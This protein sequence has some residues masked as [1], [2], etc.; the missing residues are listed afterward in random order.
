MKY[1]VAV[2]VKTVETWEIVADD[3]AGARELWEEGSLLST[4]GY[5]MEKILSVKEVAHA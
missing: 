5:E 1:Q 2:V 4:N 3:E